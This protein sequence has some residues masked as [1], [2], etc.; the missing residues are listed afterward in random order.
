MTATQCPHC[1]QS[2]ISG[3]RR[4]F[5]GPAVP[6]TCSSCGGKVGVP[7]GRTFLAM[8][9]WIVAIVLLSFVKES[10][11][12][13]FAVGAFGAMGTGILWNSIVPLVKR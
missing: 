10:G 7:F 13:S 12:L 11:P 5:I 4:Q 1:G 6:A 9:P 3:L 8:I 2:G